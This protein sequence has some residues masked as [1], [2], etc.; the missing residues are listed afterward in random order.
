MTGYIKMPKL[1]VMW[2]EWYIENATKDLVA[3]YEIG[4]L[5]IDA[6]GID[7]RQQPNYIKASEG[8]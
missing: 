2:N 3:F 4:E 5:D 8:L 1:Y 7:I 6:N